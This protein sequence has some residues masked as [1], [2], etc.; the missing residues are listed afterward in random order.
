MNNEL[1]RSVDYSRKRLQAIRNCEDHIADILWSAASKIVSKS[2]KYRTGNRYWGKW[3]SQK[4]TE[5]RSVW[6][7]TGYGSAAYRDFLKVPLRR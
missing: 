2:S 1:K 7:S 3:I 5:N 4:R 6:K